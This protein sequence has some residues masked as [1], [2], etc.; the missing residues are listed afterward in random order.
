MR[1]TPADAEA[2]ESQRHRWIKAIGC[3]DTDGFVEILSAES[4]GLSMPKPIAVPILLKCAVC[5][6]LTRR[7]LRESYGNAQV[8]HPKVTQKLTHS[9]PRPEA[10]PTAPSFPLRIGSQCAGD[11]RRLAPRAA[12]LP[13]TD[14]MLPWCTL[15]QSGPH[16]LH[17][18]NQ[19]YIAG[20][21]PVQNILCFGVCWRHVPLPSLLH[22]FKFHYYNRLG[23]PV[24]LQYLYHTTMNYCL[25]LVGCQ[26]LVSKFEIVIRQRRICLLYTS[27]AADE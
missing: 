1:P 6:G 24:S 16:N 15:T 21:C 23:F 19:D 25:R 20:R 26:G 7:L 5:G 2:I 8:A 13:G 3:G 27:D 22:A 18:F 9:P 12:Q 17:A 11:T 4:L 14:V 10:P